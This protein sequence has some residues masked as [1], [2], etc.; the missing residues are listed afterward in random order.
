MQKL[1]PTQ[2]AILELIKRFVERQRLVY[3]ALKDLQPDKILRMEKQGSPK[4]WAKLRIK[5]AYD[6]AIGLWGDN[7]EWH[8]RLH[9]IGCHLTH[10]ITGEIIGWDVGNRNHF[11]WHWFTDWLAWL[12]Q[13]DTD[14]DIVTSIRPKFEYGGKYNTELYKQIEPILL[15]LAEVGVL[16]RLRVNGTGFVLIADR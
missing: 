12:L 5:H 3:D 11:D 14:D 4:L 2:S 1:N 7:D 16:R 15:E 10:T 13:S 6:P 9:G 8:Y